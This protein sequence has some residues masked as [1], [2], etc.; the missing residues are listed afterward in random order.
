MISHY[1][2]NKPD[3][4]ISVIIHFVLFLVLVLFFVIKSCSKDK[5]IYVF[6]IVDTPSETESAPVIQP[7]P[8]PKP[9]PKPKEMKPIKPMNYEQF[10]KENPMPRQK[11]T[12]TP[13]KVKPLPDFEYRVEEI[14]SV[15]Q[16]S[17]TNATLLEKYQRYVY[18]TISTAWNKPASST[19][20]VL[21]VRVQF[22]ILP[23]GSIQSA[24]II[25]SSGNQRFDQSILN[26]FEA[27]ARFDSTP[28]GKKEAFLMN[29][30]LGD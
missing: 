1:F 17:P 27:I 18:S 26:V 9:K 7:E 25:N 23:D 21:T 4:S 20:A 8:K 5:D 14:E 10:L 29:F 15:R 16:S 24:K 30:R 11:V 28:S 12:D 19:G 3:L 6:E 13:P 22:T 2:K